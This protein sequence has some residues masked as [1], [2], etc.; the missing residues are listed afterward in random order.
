[1]SKKLICLTSFVLVLCVAAH[2]FAD[3][4]DD[5]SEDPQAIIATGKNNATLNQDSAAG[6]YTSENA[7]GT[8]TFGW[9]PEGYIDAHAKNMS[10]PLILS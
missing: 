9:V 3:W 5:F 4:S 10:L 7:S 2:T 1:M 8:A 6:F